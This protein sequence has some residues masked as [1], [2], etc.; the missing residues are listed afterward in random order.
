MMSLSSC[1]P[2]KRGEFIEGKSSPYH[3]NSLK[4]AKTL[5]SDKENSKIQYLAVI[6]LEGIVYYE[7]FNN[8]FRDMNF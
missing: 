1:P 4:E 7:I 3:G 8:I 5:A 2:V 6:S